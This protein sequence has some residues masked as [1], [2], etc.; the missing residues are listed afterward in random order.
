MPTESQSWQQY[1]QLGQRAISQLQGCT[2]N[3]Q[4]ASQLLVV[5]QQ[6]SKYSASITQ[7]LPELWQSP[8][9]DPLLKQTALLLTLCR[10]Y[11]WPAK[12]QQLLLVAS[13]SAALS[14]ALPQ[15][16]TWPKLQHYPA[17]L[18]ARLLQGSHNQLSTLLAA[19]YPTERHIPFWQQQP[20]SVVLTL[21]EVLSQSN[22][23]CSNLLQAIGTRIAVSRS[24]Y[25]LNIL[26]RLL[27]IAANS[28][29]AK[30]NTDIIANLIATSDFHLLCQAPQRQLEHYLAQSDQ[31]AGPI[32]QLATSLNRQQQNV[33]EL[34][35]ALSLLGQDRIPYLLAHAQLHQALLQ[36]HH[37]RQ[38]LLEH[39]SATFAQALMLLQQDTLPDAA[40]RALAL[41]LCAPLWLHDAS[42]LTG[43]LERTNHGWRSVLDN[44]PFR[45]ADAL[46]TVHALLKHFNM[47]QWQSA[48]TDWLSSIQS[49]NAIRTRQALVL[50]LAWHST[51]ALLGNA[52]QP[53]L[54]SLLALAQQQQ[55]LPGGH[56]SWLAQLAADCHC[57]YPLQLT[58]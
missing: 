32:L 7:P 14:S 58:L 45:R 27:D 8:N 19:C 35:L 18:A 48:A 30:S 21:I 36:C 17:L 16:K 25:E 42:W 2:D 10:H 49:G 54:A 56:D 26:R 3:A 28:T 52:P 31:L 41:C 1:Q 43:M 33:T 15:A 39:V 38:A 51:A 24:D 6:L 4:L 44:A 50:E 57:S 46:P 11:Q 34:R 12:I 5:S 40:A 53:K 9:L 37:P 55:L 47:S 13:C 23:L 29:A 20:L 22:A